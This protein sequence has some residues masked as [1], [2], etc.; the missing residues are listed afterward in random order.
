M[1]LLRCAKHLGDFEYENPL[2]RPIILPI[3]GHTMCKK[4][5]DLI[6]NERKC[7]QN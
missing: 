1:K 6:C 2:Y 3:C 5:I 7:L 4:C